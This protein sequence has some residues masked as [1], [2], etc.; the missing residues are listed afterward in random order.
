MLRYVIIDGNNLGCKLYGISAGDFSLY[1]DHLLINDLFQWLRNNDNLVI[2]LCL[3]LLECQDHELQDLPNLNIFLSPTKDG[4]DPEIEKRVDYH[5]LLG[6][7]KCLV[8][9]DD[10][11]LGNSITRNKVRVVN[12]RNFITYY[13]DEATF[14]NPGLLFKAHPEF[15]L[16]CQ[17]TIAKCPHH[18]NADLI[19]KNNDPKNTA[20]AHALKSALSHKEDKPDKPKKSA[21]NPKLVTHQWFN[22]PPCTDDGSKT[23]SEEDQLS[24]LTSVPQHYGEPDNSEMPMEE[25]TPDHLCRQGEAPVEKKLQ[26]ERLIYDLC[27]ENWP[28][29]DATQFII[30]STCPDHLTNTKDLFSN[31]QPKDILAAIDLL[32][33]NCGQ[34]NDF[35]PRSGCVLDQILRVLILQKGKPISIEEISMLTCEKVSSVRKKL[36]KH[37]GKWFLSHSPALEAYL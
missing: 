17:D 20:M 2:D 30:Q 5:L 29:K 19:K 10:T 21:A 35:I 15:P 25:N 11:N 31:M 8:V 16:L 32:L 7:Y 24:L 36:K 6:H 27:F 23:A 33:S 4:A 12:P 18:R 13:E 28:I 9:T 26:S 14:T 3:D 37:E 1:Y 34:E 22:I